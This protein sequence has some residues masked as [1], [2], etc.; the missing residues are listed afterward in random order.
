MFLV[1][2]IIPVS[3]SMEGGM[4]SDCQCTWRVACTLTVSVYEQ[5]PKKGPKKSRI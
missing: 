1:M 3:V 5:T 4:Y 2:F